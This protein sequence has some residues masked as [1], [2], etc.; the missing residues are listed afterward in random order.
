MFASAA[1]FL[2]SG[3][4]MIRPAAGAG[5]ATGAGAAAT[6]AGAGAAETGA[7]AGAGDDVSSVL[8]DSCAAEPPVAFLI[9]SSGDSPSSHRM[10]MVLPMSM[11]PPSSMTICAT[12]P[13]SKDSS[14]MVALS[15]SISAKCCP[16]LTLSPT[17]TF[18]VLT[19][20]CVIVSERRGISISM[21]IGNSCLYDVKLV[22]Y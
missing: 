5:A 9:A 14:C 8:P 12:M 20:P 15:V 18:H 3:L 21:G 22:Y 17:L 13:S 19:V 7:G 11:V 6:C 16:A 2:A 1:I 4:I 10:M